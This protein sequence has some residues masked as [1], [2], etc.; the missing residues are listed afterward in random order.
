MPVRLQRTRKTILGGLHAMRRTG[1]TMIDPS[2]LRT[3]VTLADGTMRE[4]TGV[5]IQLGLSK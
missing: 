4:L 2:F 5:G 3:R 1:P